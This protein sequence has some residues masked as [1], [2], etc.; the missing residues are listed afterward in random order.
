M[1]I[2][3]IGNPSAGKKTILEYLVNPHGF[4]QVGLEVP[5]DQ[6]EASKIVSL[7]KPILC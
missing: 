6:M 3:I 5:K 2:A 7:A 1:F 4:V